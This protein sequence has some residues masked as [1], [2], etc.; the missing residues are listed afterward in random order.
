MTNDERIKKRYNLGY[1]QAKIDYDRLIN[2]GYT[3]QDAI[4]ELSYLCPYYPQFEDKKRHK[5][6]V[7]RTFYGRGYE[8]GLN[9]IEN[10]CYEKGVDF[11][12][13]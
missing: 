9:D 1:K 13:I 6:I 7:I 2:N 12:E 11:Y 5:Y 8:Q 10:N 4:Y 3:K